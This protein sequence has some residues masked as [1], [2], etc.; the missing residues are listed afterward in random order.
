MWMN[1]YRWTKLSLIQDFYVLFAL[2]VR[3]DCADAS[4]SRKMLVTE[5]N[6]TWK[7]RF[8]FSFTDFFIYSFKQCN[9]HKRC[10]LFKKEEQNQRTCLK[11]FV[12]ISS[13]HSLNWVLSNLTYITDL[14]QKNIPNT[15]YY[16]ITIDVN[17]RPLVLEWISLISSTIIFET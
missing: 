1:K 14:L 11:T 2:F 3:G 16:M 9:W 15:E 6:I 5:G 10:L 13:I 12:F 8:L 4:N 7:N 17:K